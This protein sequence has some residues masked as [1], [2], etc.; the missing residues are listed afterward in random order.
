MT[1]EEGIKFYKDF[2]SLCPENPYKEAGELSII[3]LEKQIPKKA[4]IL[5]IKAQIGKNEFVSYVQCPNC[6]SAIIKTHE[7]KKHCCFCG[8]HLDWSDEE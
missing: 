3:A 6:K 2:I 8:Q 5:P 4:T 1:N 7:K